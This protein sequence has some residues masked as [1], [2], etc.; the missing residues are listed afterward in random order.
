MLQNRIAR[1]ISYAYSAKTRA[2][3]TIIK[4]MENT[5]GRVGLIRRAKGYDADI[6]QG[7]NFWQVMVE[8]YRLDLDVVSGSLSS[9]PATGPV[10]LLANHPYGILDGLMMG[11]ILQQTRGDFKILANHVFRK[12]PDIMESILPISFDETKESVAQNLQTRKDAMAYLDQGGA[13]GVFP[14]GT[15]ST[16][17]RMFSH[18]MDPVWRGFT[19]RM[20]AKSDATVV[21]VF[22]DGTTSRLFQIASHLHYTL[23]M[24]LLIKEFRARVGTSVK[25][26]IGDPI[27]RS[28]IDLRAK[29]TRALMDYLRQETYRLSPKPLRSVEY[30]YEFE[31]RYKKA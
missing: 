5:T 10:I 6:A 19:A 14:G 1:D 3:R 25:I 9:I 31:D 20:I 23:R 2:G 22:F 18:P 29:D 30:G 21:P 4:V 24:G 26:S 8:R 27:P 12:A 16:S 13:I 7:A 15:V 11:Y 28:E 17:K